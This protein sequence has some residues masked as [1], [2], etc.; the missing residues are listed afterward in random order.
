MH[1]FFM[2]CSEGEHPIIFLVNPFVVAILP[3]IIILGGY[4]VSI[5]EGDLLRSL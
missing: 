2:A 1:S 5:G 3:N 4:S